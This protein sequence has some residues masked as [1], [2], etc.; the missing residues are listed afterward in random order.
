[1]KSQVRK[2][3]FLQVPT[4]HVWDQQRKLFKCEGQKSEFC[5][6]SFRIT[7]KLEN[8]EQSSNFISFCGLDST[9][10]FV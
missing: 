2:G 6:V 5:Y 8:L 10:R 3:D 9:C 1:M 4:E 7:K